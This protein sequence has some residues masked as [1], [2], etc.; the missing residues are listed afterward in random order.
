MLFSVWSIP[1]SR[2]TDCS[3]GAGSGAGASWRDALGSSRSPPARGRHRHVT[4]RCSAK[5]HAPPRA[6]GTAA[7]N[8]GCN[9]V[10]CATLRVGREAAPARH[11]AMPCEASPFSPARG[12]PDPS[13]SSCGRAP[14][15]SPARGGK[16]THLPCSSPRGVLPSRR[17]AGNGACASRRGTL[18]SFALLARAGERHCHVTTRYPAERRAPYPR[19]ERQASKSLGPGARPRRAHYPRA[20][21]QGADG[22]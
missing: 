19:A 20:E 13:R 22:R 16:R 15:F 7:C 6:G 12:E 18:R 14:H 9:T 5:L 17:R 3:R 10:I 8:A 2:R 21:R 1:S 4:T 11:G